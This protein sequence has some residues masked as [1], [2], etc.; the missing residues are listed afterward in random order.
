[1]Y[2]QDN[3]DPQNV[4]PSPTSAP[5]AA[6]VEA[7][8][9]TPPTPPPAAPKKGLPKFA[10]IIIGVVLGLIALTVIGVVA[11]V[12][13]VNSATQAPVDVSN[14]FFDNLQANKSEAAYELTSSSFK[15]ATS[16]ANL[17]S[18]FDQ[19]SPFVT[20]EEKVTGKKIQASNGTSQA[21][22]TYSVENAG[23][24][25]YARVVLQKTGDKWEVI[26]FKTSATELEAIVE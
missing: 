24:T 13:F 7:P 20:G 25:R 9:A 11:L 19:I 8:Q 17:E 22:V 5:A 21:A 1:M 4:P 15:E 18:L 10:K 6:P 23:E 14:K 26:N 16:E 2:M 3:N 12:L